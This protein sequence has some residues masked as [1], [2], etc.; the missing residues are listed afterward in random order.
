MLPM[1]RYSY[2]QQQAA[3][4]ESAKSAATAGC[5]RGY[6]FTYSLV[7][8][9]ASP[10]YSD[11]RY[12]LADVAEARAYGYA[13]PGGGSG[14]ASVPPLTESEEVALMGNL[15]NPF[16]PVDEKVDG[17]QV[18]VGGC[19]M[20][21]TQLVMGAQ[22]PT[23]AQQAAE[24]ISMD[25]FQQAAQAPAVKHAVALWQ[26]CMKASGYQ[27]KSPL[28]I[29]DELKLSTVGKPGP[30]EVRV[31]VADA[32][33]HASV[34]LGPV[35][36]DAETSIEKGMISKQS[37]LLGKLFAYHREVLLRATGIVGKR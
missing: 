22:P 29:V 11:R 26:Q 18:P 36:F 37:A 8:A 31:A 16:A 2:T 34:R 10:S 19:T 4:I 32:S 13:L 17:K 30:N 7:P 25:G 24:R 23:D 6:G 35:W 27:V 12:G 21:A 5:M 3:L 9:A 14:A 28:D 20:A 15:K 1:Y 33:C